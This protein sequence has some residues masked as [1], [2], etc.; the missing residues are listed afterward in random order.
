MRLE[1][2]K[3]HYGVDISLGME[4]EFNGDTGVVTADRGH[5]VGVT[6]DKDKPGAMSNIHP[7][8]EAIKF[9]G[10]VR[11]IRGM[12]RPQR[13]YQGYLRL[14]SDLTFAEWMGF[15]S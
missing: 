11:K 6:F 15:G 3:D 1:Y 12:T 10:R 7:T 4:V 2:I 9:T 13:N 14:E 5:Y 8:D